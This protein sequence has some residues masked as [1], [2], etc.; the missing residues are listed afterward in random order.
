MQTV[1]YT[2]RRPAPLPDNVIDLQAYREQRSPAFSSRQPEDAPD[3]PVREHP[4]HPATLLEQV[5]Q[6]LDSAA[7]VALACS[8]VLALIALL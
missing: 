1:Y 5:G 4:E 3:S 7:S 2:L 8:A 6:V